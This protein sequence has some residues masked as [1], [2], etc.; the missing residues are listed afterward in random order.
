MIASADMLSVSVHSS[1]ACTVKQD[2]A[3]TADSNNI[4][5]AQVP[6]PQHLPV[7]LY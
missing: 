7:T 5:A 4:I 1:V 3:T 2:L 6:T